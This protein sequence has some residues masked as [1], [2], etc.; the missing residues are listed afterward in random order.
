MTNYVKIENISGRELLDRVIEKR[1][2][3]FTIIELAKN[4]F[5]QRVSLIMP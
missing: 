3:D 4:I 5:F 2:P 1:N